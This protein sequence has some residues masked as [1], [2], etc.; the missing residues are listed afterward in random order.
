MIVVMNDDALRDKDDTNEAYLARFNQ[1]IEEHR[2]KWRKEHAN[3]PPIDYEFVH[4]GKW[5][6]VNSGSQYPGVLLEE[7]YVGTHWA[8]QEAR[9]FCDEAKVGGASASL[10]GRLRGHAEALDSLER[11]LH[12][13]RF[14]SL[15]RRRATVLRPLVDEP[16]GFIAR[17][18]V[19]R[20]NQD[21][22]LH[23]DRF[24]ESAELARHARLLYDE[25]IAVNANATLAQHLQGL[26]EGLA[27]LRDRLHD[28]QLTQHELDDGALRRLG[29]SP[30]PSPNSSD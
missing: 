15:D 17:D 2:V 6:G 13:L 28:D 20:A 21:E 9:T 25:A 11:L 14:I 3:D 29:S 26:T 7:A 4:P 1:R 12:D 5:T 22:R 27:G 23:Q 10:V 30:K 19:D 24:V 8:A 16:G 18:D